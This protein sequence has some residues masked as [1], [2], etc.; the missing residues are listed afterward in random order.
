MDEK[1]NTYSESIPLKTDPA[2]GQ[3][4]VTDILPPRNT[5][6]RVAANRSSILKKQK[7]GSDIPVRTAARK[8]APEK[9]LGNVD[10]VDIWFRKVPA[11]RSAEMAPYAPKSGT[12]S[13]FLKK[14]QTLVIWIGVFLV[15]GAGGYAVSFAMSR[16]EILV[17]LKTEAHD[18]D[19]NISIAVEPD[20]IETLAGERL[21]LSDSATATFP[22]SGTAEVNA[23]AKGVISVYN[24]FNTSPQPL[25]ANTRFQAPDGKIYRIREAVTVPAA[26]MEHGALSPRS[27]DI[28]IYADEPGPAY[29]R[30][31]TDFTIP[32]FKGS[33]RYTGFYARS[34]TPLAGGQVGTATVITKQDAEQAREKLESE[35]RTRLADTIAK[36]VPDGFV[37]LN[38]A[39]EITTDTREFSHEAGDP[40]NE[41]TGTITFRGRALVFKKSE[42]MEFLTKEAG[43]DSSL[44]SIHNPDS[45]TLSVERR[46]MDQGI[47]TIH[48]AGNAI[49]A[50]KLDTDKLKNNLVE[51]PN[52]DAFTD[53]FRE[54]PAIERAEIHFQ[55]SWVQTVP[56][57]SS[58]IEIISN[59]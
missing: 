50:W 48:A 30:D 17:T 43:L 29:N 56:K 35:T 55:P 37:L 53:I 10:A 15:V 5:E 31:L 58:R 22:A 45:I 8:S 54:F 59:I 3:F 13:F 44:V 9:K 6:I 19:K 4:I 32:G 40:A 14:K 47:L 41:F 33:L 38:D 7:Q 27:V 39:V 12:K 1:Q 23:K 21:E 18:F 34:K 46:N 24:A 51:S 36:A 2:S 11:A 20:H 52:V 25:I 57:D 16:V 49:F 42:L 28:T 26:V